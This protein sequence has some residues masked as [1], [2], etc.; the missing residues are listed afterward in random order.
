MRG[1]SMILM[2]A[3]EVTPILR[4]QLLMDLCGWFECASAPADNVILAM[5]VHLR[6]HHPRRRKH[7]LNM[8]LSWRPF[9]RAAPDN[10]DQEEM[11]HGYL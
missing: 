3:E 4:A 8:R 10:D 9:F 5:M 1:W 2:C 6:R 11:Y 7:V